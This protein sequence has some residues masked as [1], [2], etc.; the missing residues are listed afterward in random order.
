M[1]LIIFTLANYTVFVFFNLI[2]VLTVAPLYMVL[3][4]FTP[5]S[6][7]YTQVLAH[8]FFNLYLL[9][10]PAYQWVFKK[11]YRNDVSGATV[12]VSNHQSILDMMVIHSTI[13][14]FASVAKVSLASRF[15]LNIAMKSLGAVFLDEKDIFKIKKFYTDIEK[16]FKRNSSILIFPEGSRM[17]EEKIGEFHRGAFKFATDYQVS[18]TPIV[19]FGTIKILKKNRF[20]MASDKPENVFIS[21]LKPIFPDEFDNTREM[22]KTVRNKMKEEYEKLKKEWYEKAKK[23]I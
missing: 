13:T 23:T 2:A 19:I 20:M 18:I 10:K 16:I 15:P 11:D 12:Y 3:S 7:R 5:I 1:K 6:Y 21:V 17:T 14:D 8:P 22:M 4:L 9:V